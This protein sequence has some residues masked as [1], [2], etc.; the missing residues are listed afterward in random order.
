[1]Q[2]ITQV[3]PV[4]II[5]DKFYFSLNA[6]APT[7]D[8]DSYA[9]DILEKT[10][11]IF[12]NSLLCGHPPAN[13]N[14]TEIYEHL[15]SNAEEVKILYEI[16]KTNEP[17]N[18]FSIS[19]WYND[20]FFGTYKANAIYAKI[21]E[22]YQWII[23][24]KFNAL[25]PE[26]LPVICDHLSF[27]DIS[28]LI[29]ANKH[30]NSGASL[31]QK[32]GLDCNNYFQ[33]LKFMRECTQEIKTL[34]VIR[35]IDIANISKNDLTWLVR[36]TMNR[37]FYDNTG[38]NRSKN[39]IEFLIYMSGVKKL[40]IIDNTHCWLQ[41]AVWRRNENLL[42]LLII[43]DLDPNVIL[44]NKNRDRLPILSISAHYGFLSCTRLLLENK[45]LINNLDAK[46]RTPLWHACNNSSS[47]TEEIVYPIVELLLEHGA[48][49]MI[50]DID[51]LP[52]HEAAMNGYMNVMKLLLDKGA[53]INQL[54]TNGK[55]PL[56]K[57]CDAKYE[58]LKAIQ[59]LL[60]LRADP[61]IKDAFGKTAI[62]YAAHRG[63]MKTVQQLLSCKGVNIELRAENHHTPLMEAC[64][65][66]KIN[67]AASLDL[68]NFGGPNNNQKKQAYEV[69][70]QLSE[71]QRE[72]ISIIE[73]LIASGADIHQRAKDGKQS[74]HFAAEGN[75]V[76][77]IELL[78]RAGASID[79]QDHSGET[80]LMKACASCSNEEVYTH[81]SHAK[82]IRI[83][84]Q[85]GAD[86]SLV[87][88]EGKTAFD[89]AKGKGS[90]IWNLLHAAARSKKPL[91]L[92]PG[93]LR[94]AD[95]L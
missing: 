12:R 68:L 8:F 94:N 45:A 10:Q 21:E 85:L 13:K 95:F 82:A 9:M 52:I 90:N 36:N 58:N 14:I 6:G 74:L 91:T 56:I 46:G 60:D 81:A 31:L 62:H 69:L 73:H 1:M 75:Q 83:L 87:N 20:Y 53:D 16:K 92:C 26:L 79:S 48:D 25:P 88:N 34:A 17:K 93:F 65:H 33:T 72:D 19:S 4:S 5:E 55:T 77:T 43:N 51:G 41:H 27:H 32:K 67:S 18:Y 40:G 50:G 29:R 35:H 37:V 54:S 28:S 39:L 22:L 84:L 57:A 30:L 15:M 42:K 66:K 23:H 47:N 2:N 64:S 61:H 7:T 38:T 78:I 59:F 24:P 89:M 76:K 44:K 3:F 70:S 63:H 86:P 80:P 49:Q 71:D 11:L